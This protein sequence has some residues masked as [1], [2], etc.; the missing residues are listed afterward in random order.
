MGFWSKFGKGL[1]VVVKIAA[2]ATVDTMAAGKPITLGNL[3]KS[4]AG[5]V[6]K[7]KG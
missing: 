1:K 4:T 6:A 3:G 7:K 2:Q 5:V